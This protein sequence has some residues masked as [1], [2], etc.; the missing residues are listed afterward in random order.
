M[1]EAAEPGPVH[2]AA[3]ELERAGKLEA[4]VTQNI[5]G[6]HSEAGTSSS[7]LVEVHGT[8]REASCLDCG[9]RVPIG[10]PLAEFD[11]TRVPP[12]CDECGGLMKPATISFGQPLDPLSITRSV[13]AAERCDLAVALGSTL[14]VYPAAE[15]PLHAVRRGVPYAIVNLGR[16]EHDSLPGVTLR[17]E[18]DVGEVFSAAV[19]DALDR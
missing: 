19:A 15:I 8:G 7:V 4:L 16:T 17:I 10:R 2:L 12:V 11:R 1:I 6:L 5:D 9:A 13:D 3:V 14:S 18:G